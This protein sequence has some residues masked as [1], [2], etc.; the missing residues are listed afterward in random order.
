MRHVS[1]FT[2]LYTMLLGVAAPSAA[3]DYS[4]WQPANDAAVV[5]TRTKKGGSDACCMHCTKGV[6]CGN[7]CISAKK[8][9]KSPRGCA[10]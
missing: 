1:G 10:C 2:I 4:P 7:S 3:A 9:C 6:P 5:L 8:T